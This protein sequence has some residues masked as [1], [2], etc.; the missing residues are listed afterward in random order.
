MASIQVWVYG[1]DPEFGKVVLDIH[2][3]HELDFKASSALYRAADHHWRNNGFDH[4]R[5][6]MVFIP[7]NLHQERRVMRDE[8]SAA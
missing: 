1:D 4:Y 8:V 2:E 3:V 7:S 5:R 6:K